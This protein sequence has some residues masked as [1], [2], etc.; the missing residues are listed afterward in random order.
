MVQKESSDA[1]RA[2]SLHA[3]GESPVPAGGPLPVDALYPQTAVGAATAGSGIGAAI[4]S[5][6]T[7]PFLLV[8][9]AI[10]LV[11]QVTVFS[12]HHLAWNS[13]AY[14]EWLI[15]YDGGFIRRGLSGALVDHRQSVPTLEVVNAVVFVTFAAFCLLFWWVLGNAAR[16]AAWAV[17]LALMVPNGPVHMALS[18]E[19]FYR[20]EIVFHVALGIHCIL[21]RMIVDATSDARRALFSWLFFALLLVQTV[22]F[23]LF[24]EVY[25]FIAFP[26]CWLLA[27]Q[28]AAIQ[29]QRPAMRWLCHATVAISLAM[30]GVCAMFSGNQATV[31]RIWNSLDLADRMMISPAAPDTPAGGIVAIGWSAI[32][33]LGDAGK[34]LISSQFWLWGFVAVGLGAVLVIVTSLRGRPHEPDDQSAWLLRRHL[35]QLW[36]LVLTSLPMYLIAPDWARWLSATAMSYLLLSFADST[37]AIS[38]PSLLP[39]IPRRW[40]SGFERIGD[41]AASRAVPAISTLLTRNRLIVIACALFY[42]L[43]FRP[44]ECCMK[45]G[46]N[47]FYRLKPFISELVHHRS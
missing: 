10:A 19:F 18:N 35:S 43:T 3:Q 23:P 44:P 4:R 13:W 29:P 6:L 21:Y 28:I 47:P 30:M 20:K 27:R 36:F 39:F 17:V 34:I 45:I 22:V 14:S 15:N 16:S 5:P 32:N 7:V 31:Q 1:P 40:R 9:I 11:A 26:A 2:L 42:C 8:L 25:L 41:D 46:F 24:H 33:T 37:G 38:P 12:P